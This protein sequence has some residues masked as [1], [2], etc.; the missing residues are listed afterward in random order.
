[1]KAQ[2]RPT[3][4]AE[5]DPN[6]S[7]PEK[8]RGEG[9]ASVLLVDDDGA[10]RRAFGRI[11]HD[12]GYTVTP[13]AD[14]AAALSLLEDARFDVIVSDL[15]MPNLGGMDL[16]RAVRS[17]DLDVPVILVTGVPEIDSAM[18]AVEYGALRYL[19]KPVDAETLRDAVDYATRVRALGALKREA[20]EIVGRNAQEAADRAGLEATFAKT[21]DTLWIAFQ[22]II[23]RPE[24]RIYGYEAL[25]RS[26]ESALPHPGAVLDAAE[27]LERVT[28]VGRVVRRRVAETLTQHPQAVDIFVNLHPQD[29]RDPEL[30][31][32]RAPLSSHAAR[33][34]LEI[35][36]RANIEG[37][38]DLAERVA[39]LR[40]MGY[41]L[42]VDDLG[43]GY[44]G[45]SSFVRLEPDVVKIDMSLIRDLHRDSTRARVVKSILEL[46]REMNI[47]V[48][49][50]G[51]ECAEEAAVLD[52]M[53]T[54]L[55]QGY[56]FG[57]PA[58][59]FTLVPE[60]LLR[61]TKP[62]F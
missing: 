42:A 49:A 9:K 44:A 17:R 29:L 54:P 8:H 21:L 31:D 50:E 3:A 20:M 39:R 12:V 56:Y 7:V 1:M 47:N 40:M 38:H 11:L 14:G 30:Y 57:R 24:S 22:P 2:L 28:E 59:G 55:L 19:A 4:G 25:M 6:G 16:L 33:I 52:E 43:A 53:G 48:V 34:V 58:E 51:I 27:R 26:R 32:S 41:R 45:L 18:K 62:S 15:S 35:T 36:E 5:G 10:V 60:E 46:C 23:S 61:R 13:A 37:L